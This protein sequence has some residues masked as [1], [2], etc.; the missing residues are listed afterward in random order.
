MALLLGVYEARELPVLHMSDGLLRGVHQQGRVSVAA[1]AE[2]AM[3]GLHADREHDRAG[4][5][6]QC[7]RGTMD[8]HCPCTWSFV[9]V[10]MGGGE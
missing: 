2:G 8:S 7:G 1:E 6:H 10:A 4:R 5:D 3:R 9:G